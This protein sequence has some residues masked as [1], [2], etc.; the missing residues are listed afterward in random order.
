[1]R[2]QFGE[3]VSF[4][5]PA[6]LCVGLFA[7]ST[8]FPVTAGVYPAVAIPRWVGLADVGF[9]GLLVAVAIVVAVQNQARVTDA[10]R[11]AA[12]RVARSVIS[13]IPALLLLFF[14]AGPRVHWEVLVVGLAWR[15][16]LVMYTLPALMA[17]Q[18]I[19][20]RLRSTS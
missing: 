11:L 2:S 5:R 9:A 1:V 12:F 14:I 15:G 17:A 16:W 7:I 10:D 20:G 6:R 18:R 8:M 3:M 13:G 4:A 19:G